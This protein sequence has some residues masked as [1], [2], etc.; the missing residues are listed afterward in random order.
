MERLKIIK[1]L[2][3]EFCKDSKELAKNLSIRDTKRNLQ[4]QDI[5]PINY[6][7]DRIDRNLFNKNNDYIFYLD[8]ENH[9]T[10]SLKEMIKQSYEKANIV[11]DKLGKYFKTKFSGRGF[12]MIC[13]LKDN[14][15]TVEFFKKNKIESVYEF[16]KGVAYGIALHLKLSS[17]WFDIQQLNKNGMIR[18]FCINDKA[19]LNGKKMYSVPVNLS[20]DSL[21]D[22]IN[23]SMLLKDFDDMFELP[24]FELFEFYK[25]L[26]KQKRNIEKRLLQLRLQDADTPI[27]LDIKT[28]APCLQNLIKKKDLGNRERFI[29]IATLLSI[30]LTPIDVLRIFKH[31][32]SKSTFDKM[33]NERQIEYIYNDNKRVRNCQVIKNDNLCP[34]CDLVKPF[35][36]FSTEE[37]REE[38]KSLNT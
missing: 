28:L 20:K 1:K 37:K 36:L 31:F 8:V 22:I 11:N 18:G 5:E 29:L 15:Q 30:P 6:E 17:D 24:E 12:H 23:K 13:L 21:N 14:K 2:N 7:V 3:V 32:L 27:D 16:S 19:I 9:K 26:P 4:F 34:E 33:W 25:P 38:S 10:T 35:F